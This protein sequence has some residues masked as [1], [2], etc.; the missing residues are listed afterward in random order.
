MRLC[1]TVRSKYDQMLCNR[2]NSIDVKTLIFCLAKRRS[3]SKCITQ[4][5]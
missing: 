4:M 5:M 1:N 2:R 3:R